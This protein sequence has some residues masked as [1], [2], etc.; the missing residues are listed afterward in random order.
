MAVGKVATKAVKRKVAKP[1]RE[2]KKAVKSAKKDLKKATKKTA[3]ASPPSAFSLVRAKK[4][5][6]GTAVVNNAPLPRPIA[7]LAP[8]TTTCLIS[9]EASKSEDLPLAADVVDNILCPFSASAVY[10]LT[11]R[12]GPMWVEPPLRST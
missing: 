8:R 12:E 4:V 10:K 7:P 2:T 1:V 6:R 5:T 3:A 9:R 11:S